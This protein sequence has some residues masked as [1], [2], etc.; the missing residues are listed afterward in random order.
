MPIAVSYVRFSSTIQEKGSSLARQQGYIDEWVID[1]PGIPLSPIKFSDLG[2]SGFSGKHLN[3]DFGKI[4]AAI[5]NKKIVAGDYLL[6]E[7]LDRLGRLQTSEMIHHIT[8]IINAGIIIITLEDKV[9]YDKDS[10][11]G[12]AL[13]QLSGKVQQAHGESKRKS[14]MIKKSYEDRK[15]LA[16]AGV[17]IKRKTPW[18]L[19]LDNTITQSDKELMNYIF[20][21]YLNGVSQNEIVRQLKSKQPDRFVKYSPTALKK[22]LINK[23]CI[24][25][26]GDVKSV[27]PPAVSEVLFYSVQK[28]TARRSVGKFQGKHT[29]EINAGLVVCNECGSNYSVR[30]QKH[31]TDVMYCSKANKNE[32][33][34]TNTLPLPLI[35]EFRIKTQGNYIKK[36]AD[37]EMQTEEEDKL[38]VIDGKI[39]D[40]NK[41]LAESQKIMI[42]FPSMTTGKAIAEMEQQIK[43]LV[44]ER[45]QTTNKIGSY[46]NHFSLYNDGLKLGQDKALLNGM[47]K[48]IGYKI[49]ASGKFMKI[50]V[51]EWE[52]KRYYMGNYE[53]IEDG[54]LMTINPVTQEVFD[55]L[56]KN[57]LMTL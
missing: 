37:S 25:Y 55:G 38:I 53:V 33:T 13:W 21:S 18:F 15:K 19:Q 17:Q 6:I 7:A 2:I 22:L 27:Y 39:D 28:E 42:A 31:S 3:N 1:N 57:K 26:W 34:N 32:C 46:S 47:L 8:G 29:N 50:D 24:G 41:R 16:E 56:T 45:T 40:L 9:T 30:R 52:Y 43:D 20:S 14:I 44:A 36:I 51:F 23:T 11:D 54:S 4:L 35:N 48:K 5:K 10:L 12:G 49:I